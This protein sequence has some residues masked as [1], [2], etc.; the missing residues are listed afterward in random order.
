M[1]QLGSPSI[2]YG[3]LRTMNSAG[4]GC[5]KH[6]GKR[7]ASTPLDAAVTLRNHSAHRT[8]SSRP[9]TSF[10]WLRLRRQSD[11]AFR[12]MAKAD[13]MC[14]HFALLIALFTGQSLTAAEAG[15]LEPNLAFEA[16][17]VWGGGAVRAFS[18]T[19]TIT[20]GTVE[21]VRNL[22][23]QDDAVGSLRR[24]STNAIE[25]VAHSPS[26]FGGV[27]LSINGPPDAELEFQWHDSSDGPDPKPI[28]IKLSQILHER[29]L[30]PID[31]R[32][33]RLAVERHSHDRLRASINHGQ[34]L[35]TLGER[36]TLSVEGYCNEA[37]KGDYRLNVRL[38]EG[39][40]GR[41]I[42]H[43]QRDVEIDDR[44]CFD[45]QVFDE[46]QS[47]AKAGVYWFDI[48][49]QR[50][51]LMNSFIN[52]I[53]VSDR[54]CEFVVT[55]RQALASTETEWRELAQV[56]PA[57]TSWWDSVG[58]FRVPSVKTLQPLVTHN[59][60]PLSSMEHRRR[61]IGG[62]ECMVLAPGAWQA[63]PLPVSST[64]VPHRVRIRVPSDRPQK[65]ILSIQESASPAD[66]SG[67][68]LDS[69]MVIGPYATNA[70]DF[71]EHELIFWPKTSQPYLLALNADSIRDASLAEVGLA[72]ASSGL[73]STADVA[74]LSTS[75]RLVSL[76]FDKP[77]LSENFGAMR[78]ADGKG[79]RELDTW[80]TAYEAST[81]LAEYTQWSGH[82]AATI[83]VATQGGAT[84]PSKLLSPST[85]FDSGTF[86]S[87]GSSPEIKDA[88]ELICR[89]FDR[90]GLKLVLAI[91]LE[92][93][94]PE[95]LRFD[96]TGEADSSLFQVA[97][98]AD[99][100]VDAAV[101]K[102]RR[103]ARYNPLD[104]R[105]QLALKRVVGELLDR[106]AQHD[107]F[108]G[109]Q[110]NL[111]DRSHFNFAGDR[112]GYDATSLARFERSIGAALP[113]DKQEREKLLSGTLHL[114]FLSERSARLSEFYDALAQDVVA[115]K[116]GALLLINPAKLLAHS[117]S[118]ETFADIQSR[119]PTPSEILIGCGIDTTALSANR[120]I[121]F[122]RPE[123]DS[124]LRSSF[125]RS[126]AFQ[127]ASDTQLDAA[128]SGSPAGV[129]LHQ[130]PTD[131]RLPE[132]D[133]AAPFGNERSRTWLFPQAS[134]AGDAARRSMVARLFQSDAQ[135]MMRGGW[136]ISLGQEAALR[137]TLNVLRRLPAVTMDDLTC[138]KVSATLRV[139]RVQHDG[140]TYLQV[141]NNASWQET[142]VIE[143]QSQHATT[144]TLL[145]PDQ[146]V[147]QAMV[148]GE[149]RQVELQLAAY[150]V[151]GLRIDG[152][153]IKITK[154]ISTPENG[155]AERL[156]RRLN[157]LQ[158]F[159]DRAAE[160]NVQ[161]T[162]GLRGGDFE[163]W[164]DDGRPI[165]WTIS[166]Q[167]T[168]AIVRE[169]E[170]PRSGSGCVRVENNGNGAATAWI[171]SD[172]IAI[173][174][175]GRLA[176]E[177]WVRSAPGLAQPS[178]RLSVLGRDRDGKRFQRWHD[179]VPTSPGSR[180]IPIDWG[181]R[182]LVLLVPDVP[183]DELTEL[184][185]AIDLVGP[186]R[187]WIDDV[188]VYGM[189]LHPDERVHLLGQMYLA[190][191]HLRKGNFS[192]ADRLLESFWANFLSNT[193]SELPT[194]SSKVDP[195]PMREASLP[196]RPTTPTPAWRSTSQPRLNQW[197]ESLRQRWQR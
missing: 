73:T 156:E 28:R 63:F 84:Y 94:L 82:N 59:A 57:G 91:E 134:E 196:Q 121:C 158:T 12:F 31:G 11:A 102:P 154:V 46:I 120:N 20:G 51:R 142:V 182:P 125:A 109:V 10:R 33:S 7:L 130:S 111:S 90:R 13:R 75:P 93:L 184:Q 162:L 171:Q 192:L 139:R 83:T 181:R 100:S 140:R 72:L 114:N 157:E 62:T 128:L 127:L 143:L 124:L 141:V 2:F 169:G 138:E 136:M 78:K 26:A 66:L 165:G 24:K 135:V 9:G 3:L 47:P 54:R 85:K 155:V 40:S 101:P 92:G 147:S 150:S 18:G 43:Y 105:V 178:V 151:S 36:C 137:G 126:W 58:T 23:V 16:R 44:G 65:L 96:E 110:I 194:A 168:T 159:I 131:F 132:F 39:A 167:P 104:A 76:Y 163:E 103:I 106:Y 71:A 113:A 27:D 145:E 161:Q 176:L 164:T 177:V 61:T 25:I 116:A 123:S 174:A 172:R 32:G 191:D 98:E 148:A 179:F 108:A 180:D 107:C 6:R 81:R 29:V 95:L 67:L 5:P 146:P 133:S 88:T 64:G 52:A 188:R 80:R 173:P 4:H 152:D 55:D 149:A 22:S 185:V 34:A 119:T 87:D 86:L 70:K 69:A 15:K 89:E 190:K 38:V 68:K 41:A 153:D 166:T 193:L 117:P 118:D 160:L 197:Q 37:S 195:L 189:Y 19:I 53:A 170:L 30:Q 56:Y 97:D 74:A 48:S 115:S 60:K 187:L 42:S 122:L 14:T 175:T 1:S 129:I 186:G 144:L 99:N 35:L 50:R 77:L 79:Q 112:W 49:V 17:A 21:I 8:D 183:S 45:A